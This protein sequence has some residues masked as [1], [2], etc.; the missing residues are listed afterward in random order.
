MQKC[1]YAEIWKL[2]L[3]C[4]VLCIINNIHTISSEVKADQTQFLTWEEKQTP[5]KLNNYFE[6]KPAAVQLINLLLEDILLG[7]QT[8]WCE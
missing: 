8:S 1:M 4:V 6:G 5:V 7:D 3:N 2:L